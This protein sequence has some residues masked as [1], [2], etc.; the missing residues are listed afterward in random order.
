MNDI[1]RDRGVAMGLTQQVES[2][3]SDPFVMPKNIYA[4]DKGL[5]TFSSLWL[6]VV[7]YSYLYFMKQL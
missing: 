5:T 4:L 7:A 6:I 1:H 2:V 3:V